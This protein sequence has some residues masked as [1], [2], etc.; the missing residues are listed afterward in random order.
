MRSQ[1]RGEYC[2]ILLETLSVYVKDKRFFNLLAQYVKRT[3]EYGGLFFTGGIWMDGVIVLLGSRW[4][5]QYTVHHPFTN[6][7][8][9]QVIDRYQQL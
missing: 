4:T 5:L 6:T 1:S 9:P 3:V 8:L 2:E 7:F